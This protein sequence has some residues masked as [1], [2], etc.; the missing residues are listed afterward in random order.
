[1]SVVDLPAARKAH[2]SAAS[3]VGRMGQDCLKLDE[4]IEEAEVEKQ[5]LLVRI[6]AP[7][8]S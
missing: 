4:Q 7:A 3:D 8:C 6:G 5:Q 1:M 2:E